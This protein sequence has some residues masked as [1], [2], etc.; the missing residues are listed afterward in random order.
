M[1]R[2]KKNGCKNVIRE[3]WNIQDKEGLYFVGAGRCKK[4]WG[5]WME[6]AVE[7]DVERCEAVAFEPGDMAAC[8][9]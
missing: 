2:C 7:E 3:D 5:R 1:S 4:N 9:G 6:V 8:L